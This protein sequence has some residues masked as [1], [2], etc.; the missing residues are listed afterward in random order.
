MSALYALTSLA[1]PK[2]MTK[3]QVSNASDV[4]LALK[5]G[6]MLAKV[7]E[8]ALS[9]YAQ[10]HYKEFD[11][12]VADQACQLRT[13]K[14]LGMAM[15]RSPETIIDL[16]AKIKDLQKISAVFEAALKAAEIPANPKPLSDYLEGVV[17]G[18]A[19]IELNK[20]L[21]F[22]VLS[23]LLKL[24]RK[25][26][27]PL[28]TEE[29]NINALIPST[30]L[31]SE[32]C[33]A[34]VR[35]AKTTLAERSVMYLR[36]VIKELPIEAGLKKD[37]MHAISDKNVVE[38]NNVKISSC[39]YN[40]QILMEEMR[41]SQMPMILKIN[42]VNAAGVKPQQTILIGCVASKDKTIVS[43]DVKSLKG[44]V[45]VVEGESI[46]EKEMSEKDYLHALLGSQEDRAMPAYDRIREIILANASMHPHYCEP[47][48]AE[49]KA[50]KALKRLEMQE[51]SSSYDNDRPKGKKDGLREPKVSEGLKN[52]TLRMQAL[53]K[54][55]GLC[56]DNPKLFQIKHIYLSKAEDEANL[57]MAVPNESACAM[58][59]Q[60]GSAAAAVVTKTVIDSVVEQQGAGS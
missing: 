8:Q 7:A 12:L 2:T 57:K 37:L 45:M 17:K 59:Q 21:Q 23:H 22:L 47:D 10:E 14:I 19:A 15:H 50:R 13:V 36:Q 56:R 52:Y 11:A 55:E 32:R 18:K 1:V 54:K 44:A 38:H 27:N 31:P 24:T 6:I 29:V 42:R 26:T 35:C 43:H 53:A 40:L 58:P 5:T 60:Q 48:S 20:D 3:I 30:P 49:V 9:H 28:H 25:A 46:N 33:V 51:K 16:A 41:N 39:M 4:Q 34:I